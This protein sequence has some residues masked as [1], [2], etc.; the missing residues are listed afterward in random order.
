MTKII[1]RTIIISILSGSPLTLLATNSTDHEA[2]F[3]EAMQLRNNGQLL[4]SI[5]SFE[6]LLN[7]Q[8][9]LHRVRLELAVAYHMLQRFKEAREQLYQVLNN[10]ETPDTVKLTITGYLAQLGAD[11]KQ[12]NQRTSDNLHISFGLFT[13]SNVNIAPS[14]IINLDPASSERDATGSTLLLNYNHNSRASNPLSGDG[15]TYFGWNTSF[16][17]Y[18][19]AHTDAENDFNLHILSLE[20]GP[21]II[22]TDNWSLSLNFKLDKIYFDDNPYADFLSINPRFTLSFTDNLNLLLE[23]KISV[24]EFSNLSESGLEGISKLYGIGIAKIFSSNNS[25]IEFSTL[26]HSNGAADGQL[27]YSGLEYQLNGHIQTW[28]NAKAY[29]KLSTRDYEYK[30]IRIDDEIKATAGMSHEFTTGT[31]KSWTLNVQA[32]YTENDSNNPLYDYER[33]IFETNLSHNF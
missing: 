29:L 2:L 5:Q 24:R 13:D 18:S 9:G 20:T 31:L 17:G 11:E 28:E 8:P 14:D 23:N 33:T 4:Q 32:S 30:I 12:S 6:S 21:E 27:N 7:S 15:N 10:P 19:K 3:K 16:T 22:A 1:L 25:G 26:Y